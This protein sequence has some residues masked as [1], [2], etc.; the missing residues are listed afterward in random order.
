VEAKRLLRASV[1][2]ARAAR[3][4][5]ER[6]RA[7]VDLV[8]P[9][10]AVVPSAGVVLGYAAVGDEPPTRPLLDALVERG[11]QV[12][13]PVVRGRELVWGRYAG[14][15]LL[16]LGPLGL[17]EPEPSDTATVIASSAD[18]AVVPAL[19][20]DRAGHRLGRGGG[21]YDRWLRGAR[22]ATVAAVVFADEVR[23]SVPYE[24]H[25]VMVDLAI[26]PAGALALGQ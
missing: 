25:D 20:V 11:A 17:L 9:T 22:P 24:P 21:F 12:L 10:L 6:Q 5:D 2:A 26:T 14:W 13:L 16:R 3:S 15:H 1:L 18:A 4:V 23:D 7:G 8:A 19:A